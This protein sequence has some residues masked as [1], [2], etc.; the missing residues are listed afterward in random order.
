MSK[1]TSK[2]SIMS[3]VGEQAKKRV[4]ALHS[5]LPRVP[6]DRLKDF[7]NPPDESFSSET[8]QL[9][10]VARFTQHLFANENEASASDQAKP[11]PA[12]ADSGKDSDLPSLAIPLDLID[13]NPLPPRHYYSEEDLQSLAK[14]L[15]VN[16]LVT[17]INVYQNGDRYVLIEGK[18]RTIV[19]RRLGWPAISAHIHPKPRT[20]LDLYLLSRSCNVDRT[21]QTPLDDAIAWKALLDQGIVKDQQSLLDILTARSTLKQALDHT[22]LSR[23]LNLN[24]LPDS[25]KHA[26]I[27]RGQTDLRF[28]NAARMY[29]EAYIESCMDDKNLAGLSTELKASKAEESLLRIFKHHPAKSNDDRN[30]LTAKKLEAMVARIKDKKP[31]HAQRTEPAR[32]EI[33]LNEAVSLVFKE[34]PDGRLLIEG[35]GLDEQ[36]FD[37]I[38]KALQPLDVR[39]GE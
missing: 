8:P 24:V 27:E 29:F 30:K 36:Q 6:A 13:D 18:H 34:F 20:A 38:R 25:V 35:A 19:A 39:S 23:I 22:K 3:R 37:A 2:S 10:N 5:A 33:R 17:P 14:S 21:A 15:S 4:S 16:G 12:I 26:C 7:G 1:Q 9:S 11:A 28:L 32:S 31:L